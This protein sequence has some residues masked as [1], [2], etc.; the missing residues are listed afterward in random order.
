MGF[1]EFS[2]MARSRAFQIW[3]AI[4]IGGIL[5][6]ILYPLCKGRF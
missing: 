6:F 4:W 3:Y 5:A 2:Y 1:G